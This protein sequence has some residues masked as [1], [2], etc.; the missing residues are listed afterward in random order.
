MPV[1]SLDALVQHVPGVEAE[2]GPDDAGPGPRRTMHQAQE[3]PG[4]APADLGRRW[5]LDEAHGRPDGIAGLSPPIRRFAAVLVASTCV[6]CGGGRGPG[7]RRRAPRPVRPAPA[8]VVEGL[9]RVWALMA[10]DGAA[11]EL[12]RGLKFTNRRGALGVLVRSA[13]ARWST[14]R[15]RWSPGCPPTPAHRR[16]RG[17]DQGRV[18]GPPGR[19]G[20]WTGRPAA[21]SSAQ[22]DRPQTG[23]DRRRP[24][25]SG[26]TLGARR[27]VRGTVLVV[28]DVVTTGGSLAAAA[29]AL[30]AGRCRPRRSALVLA[31]TPGLKAGTRLP[32]GPRV[33][34][35]FDDADLFFGVDDLPDDPVRVVLGDDNGLYRRGL[36]TALEDET[37]LE[38]VAEAGPGAD[39]IAAVRALAPDV[40]VCS[41]SMG[42]AG[43]VET[44]YAI[45]EVMPLVRVAV[46]T[47]DQDPLEQDRC[48]GPGRRPRR[49]RQGRRPRGGRPGHPRAPRGLAGARARDLGRGG[50]RGHDVAGA[51][52]RRQ[53]ARA[54]RCW[55]P[56]PAAPTWAA[57]AD[58]VGVRAE[59]ARNQVRNLLARGRAAGYPDAPGP[60]WGPGWS[61]LPERPAGA[62]GSLHQPWVLSIVSSAPVKARRCVPS[63]RS[64]PTS[65]AS[66]PSCEALE[67]RGAAGQDRRVQGPD[68]AGRRGRRPAHRGLRGD[69]R[70]RPS[71]HRPAP[72]RRPAHGRGRPALRLGGRDEDR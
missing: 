48:R 53:G 59:A 43:G 58:A 10:Y 24:A 11:R 63:P 15:S 19:P 29:R 35:L 12:I 47:T 20:R 62:A 65:T 21:C 51:R 25:G 45:T 55:P 14:T 50:R 72:L 9:D 57:A 56:W 67:R 22:G 17:Y 52:G 39:L 8:V 41:L 34:P 68:R 36:L 40:V 60:R 71:G 3:Q 64:S 44:T 61:P 13:A 5:G 33:E 7:V 16:A 54:A 6:A 28:D 49:D 37:D 66:S 31:A 30:R 38:V 2:V 27:P 46:L 23:L 1:C 69:P 26:L 42:N 4:E 18:A 32:M 70:G